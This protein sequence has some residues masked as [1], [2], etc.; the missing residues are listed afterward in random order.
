MRVRAVVPA[1]LLAVVVPLSLAACG[2]DDKSSAAKS[3]GG[4]KVEAYD[5]RFDPK[6]LSAKVGQKMTLTV[7]N[8]G[9]TEH[10]FSITS[11]HVDQDVEKGKDATVSFTPTRGGTLQF[12]CEYHRGRGMTGTIDVSA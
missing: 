5:F 10:N 11:L 1:V 12:F 3:S 7:A 9:T 8:E 6:T 2:K 4:K